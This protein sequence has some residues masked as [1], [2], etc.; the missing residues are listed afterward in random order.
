MTLGYE[1]AVPTYKR[2][3]TVCDKTLDYL[4]RA[5]VPP[6]RVT[7]FVADP[8]EAKRYRAAIVDHGWGDQYRIVVGRAGLSAQRNFVL[9]YYPEGTL[10]FS[11]DD[12][13]DRLEQMVSRK[14]TTE[15]T[16]LPELFAAAS[17][18]MLYSGLKLW[19][20]YPIL[21][22]FYMDLTTTFDLK[23]V[24]GCVH[25]F[26]STE[27]EE[28]QVHLNMKDDYERTL[29]YYLKD[30]GVVRFNWVAPKTKYYS[31]Q[32]GLAGYRTPE[33]SEAEA[34]WLMKTFPGL[35]RI[36]PARKGIWTEVLLRDGNR[37]RG[38]AG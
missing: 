17:A 21:N 6:E 24:V 14:A 33:R 13:I 1:V 10:V 20:I 26:Y 35:V 22:P 30:G 15:V 19:G 28:R 7:L 32:G 8:I 36:N 16:N 9:S 31:D 38:A 25:A 11:F 2:Y 23:F 27:D 4:T 37:S 5:G 3:E 18:A 29:R 12:D 34:R